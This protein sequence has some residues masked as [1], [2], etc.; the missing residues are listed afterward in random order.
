MT[1]VQLPV[2]YDLF[3][4]ALSWIVSAIGAF[5][6]LSAVSRARRPD[7]GVD[8]FNVVM[9]GV[10]LGG[11]GIWSM[12][13]IGMLAWKVDLGVGY[14]LFETMV[15]LV[16]AVVV[17]ALALGY[18]AAGPATL[19]RLLVAGP[20]AGIGVTV[21]HY[22]GMYS[23]RFYG[24][25]DWDY[26]TVGVSALIAM[27]AATAALWLAFNTHKRW[28]RAIAAQVMATA[29]CTMHYTGMAAASV[30]CTTGNRKAYL[31]DLLRPSDLP[32]LVLTI[33]LGVALM[34]GTDLTIQRLTSDRSGARPSPRMQGAS[35]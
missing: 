3:L 1:P 7:G 24:F 14:R 15:S 17:S 8:R 4:I 6:A 29:V 12:H 20:L 35:R 22:L 13:F 9:A 30:M 26:K 32:S 2:S 21:M 33:A 25:F 11:I 27:T 28:H 10:A 5:T 23:M 31:P 19:R 34:I 16:A 18:V